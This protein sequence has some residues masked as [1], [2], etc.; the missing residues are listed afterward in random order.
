MGSDSTRSYLPGAK[1]G[2]ANRGSASQ[3]KEHTGRAWFGGGGGGIAF[4][5]ATASGVHNFCA[6]A[7]MLARLSSS[8]LMT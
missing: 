1:T 5:T 2:I 4:D 3:K 7:S 6:T 8:A